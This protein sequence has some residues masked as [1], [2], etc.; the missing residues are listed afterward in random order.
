M[1]MIYFVCN[2]L[3]QCI[4][5]IILGINLSYKHFINVKYYPYYI[6]LMILYQFLV[7]ILTYYDVIK[8]ND[9]K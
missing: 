5:L 8:K 2:F 3:V 7:M 1:N 4:L 9:T 6:G